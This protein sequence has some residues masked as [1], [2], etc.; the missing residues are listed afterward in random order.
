MRD[1]QRM[2]RVNQPSP[3]GCRLSSL[4]L[5]AAVTYIAKHSSANGKNPKYPGIGISKIFHCWNME[6][7]SA[8]S[9]PPNNSRT[10]I[11]SRRRNQKAAMHKNGSDGLGGNRP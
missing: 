6:R 11:A 4:R 8:T 3:C 5:H 10:P 7:C 1:H 9:Q 2:S